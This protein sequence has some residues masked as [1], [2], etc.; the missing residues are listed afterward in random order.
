M[1]DAQ[2]FD[3]IIVGAGSAGCVL[4]SRL[5]EDEKTSV[6]ILE[7][8][9]RD[10]DPWI[11]IPL[12]WAKMLREK[13]HQWGYES[14]P[15][16][17]A[18]NR[19]IE[20]ARGKV[21][22]GSWSIN[23][24]AFV[25]GNPADFDRWAANGLREWDYR[26]LLP[27]FKRSEDY[28]GGADAYRATGGPVRV[29]KGLGKTPL[30]EAY[31]SAMLGLGYPWTDDFNGAENEGLGAGQYTIR[32]GRRDSGVTAYLKPALRR[33]NLSLQL[34]SFATQIIF[35]DRKAVGIRYRQGGQSK[36]AHARKEVIL[37]GGV[38]NSPHLLM[39]SGIGPA[40]QLK[41]HGIDVR[42]D[43][44]DVGRN[45]QD[46]I[47]VPVNF[48]QKGHSRFVTNMR[49]DRLAVNIPRAYLFGTGPS[50][51]YPV[52]YMAFIKSDPAQKI[53]DLQFL[54]MAGS[55]SAHPWFPGIRKPFRNTFGCRA[56]V[57]HPK[58]RGYLQLA[59][60]DPNDRI[61]IFQ[62][63]FSDEDDLVLLRNGVR[64][65]RKCLSQ[66]QLD[67][68]RGEETLPGAE[69]ETDEQIDAYIR[70]TCWTVHHPL[71]TCRMG[72][73]AASVVDSELRVRGAEGLRIV[74]ASVMPDMTGGNINAAVIAIAER[75]SDIIRGRTPLTN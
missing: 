40:D 57:L 23:A 53:P 41:K 16:P 67:T 36:V 33:R 60:N 18:D 7:A 69:I 59:S 1:G 24:M 64:L 61:K 74:D 39:L 2:E 75:A 51:R 17:H 25:R 3:Y 70:R 29:V 72:G 11:S 62:N 45:L 55:M 20:I 10:W 5:S 30:A 6:L 63:F 19:R 22:G 9:G 44:G 21:L 31:L 48:Y 8:G 14:E 58:S 32:N 42:V 43:S 54:F 4:A 52:G 56:A 15:E 71:G 50:A 47:S 66:P 73:D 26:H 65:I 37:C 46:H 12:G 49:L 38:F 34:K 28:E 13:R 35:K 27:Y 68:F